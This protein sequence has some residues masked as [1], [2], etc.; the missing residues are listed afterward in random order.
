MTSPFDDLVRRVSA[1]PALAEL[2]RSDPLVALAGYDLTDD[3]LRRLDRIVRPLAAG[4]ARPVGDDT[5]PGA[6]DASRG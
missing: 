5:H 1:D 4:A 2:V 3:D 6:R